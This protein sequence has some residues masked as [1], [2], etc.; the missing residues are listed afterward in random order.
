[1]SE[2]DGAESHGRLNAETRKTRVGE[3]AFRNGQPADEAGA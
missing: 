1:M 3:F 2:Q